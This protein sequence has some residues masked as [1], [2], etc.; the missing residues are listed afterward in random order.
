MSSA[1]EWVVGNLP[2]ISFGMVVRGLDVVDW[3]VGC[4]VVDWVV[5]VVVD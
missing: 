1:S 5:E 4:W 2:E 3:V